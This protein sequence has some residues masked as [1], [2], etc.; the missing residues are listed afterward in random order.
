MTLHRFRLSDLPA[1][2][3]KNGGGTTR[4]IICRPARAG[5]DCFDWR[6]SIASIAAA[7]P[8]SAFPGVDR[9]IMLLQGAGVHLRAEGIDHRLETPLVPFAFAGDVA[10]GCELLGGPS[11][12][13]NV[14]TRRGVLRAEVA[15]LRGA[16]VLEACSAGLVLAVGGAWQLGAGHAVERCA[17]DSGAWWDSAMP[18]LP[19]TPLDHGAALVVVRIAEE[20]ERPTSAVG[21]TT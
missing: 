21:T 2:P 1:T 7:G 6:V 9:V 18:P 12:D 4:E 11:T 20:N 3:W 16:G 13:F 19:A 8:F 14:M 17:A 15:V 10:L 5:M